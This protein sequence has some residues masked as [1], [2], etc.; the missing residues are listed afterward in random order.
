MG[1]ACPVCDE[2]QIDAEHLAN[3]LAFTAILRGGDHETWLD[4]HAPD[5]DEMGPEA[6]AAE[7]SEH[8]ETV[9]VEGYEP[10]ESMDTAHG[11]GDHY[12]ATEERTRGAG[13]TREPG[14]GRSSGIGLDRLS[15]ED[16]AVLEE[17][18]DLT[19]QMLEGESAE[20][21]GADEE[22]AERAEK[23]TDDGA[24]GDSETE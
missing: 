5:W 1:Y 12:A 9:D 20:T 6:L 7:V 17:A 13:R 16:R 3:H 2:R 8:A 10:G 24:Q 18:R 21:S 22:E 19:R 23:A 14:K 4:R 11:T 15:A